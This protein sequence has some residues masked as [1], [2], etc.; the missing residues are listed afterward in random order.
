L[1]R[2]KIRLSIAPD[3]SVQDES[4]MNQEGGGVEKIE[5]E[6][7]VQSISHA[8]AMRVLYIVPLH[9]NI[10]WLRCSILSLDVKLNCLI[11]AA[12]HATHLTEQ[13]IKLYNL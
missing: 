9:V 4:I 13:P 8:P 12:G 3:V 11:A 6:L 1:Y 5:H 10:I 7:C 2:S